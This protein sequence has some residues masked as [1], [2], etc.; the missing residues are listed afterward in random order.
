MNCFISVKT[1]AAVTSNN[2]GES[3]ESHTPMQKISVGEEGAEHFLITSESF[4]SAYRKNAQKI[5]EF[6]PRF[7]GIPHNRK[8]DNDKQILTVEF[9]QGTPDGTSWDDEAMGFLILDK[10]HIKKGGKFRGDTTV[11]NQPP[12]TILPWK[13]DVILNQS[14]DSNV[15]HEVCVRSR[16]ALHSAYQY[17]LAWNLNDWSKKSWAQ[18]GLITIGQMA[19]VAGNQRAYLYDM[20]PASLIIRLRPQLVPGFDMLA[21]NTNGSHKVIEKIL[22]GDIDGKGFFIA[23]EIICDMDATMVEQLREKG[24]VVGRNCEKMLDLVSENKDFWED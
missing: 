23:G 10:K 17:A 9:T 14:P 20:S 5:C 24:V 1:H 19:G 21:W 8:R 16:E 6:D 2:G 12:M 3:E 13:N 4:R 11:R 15:G 22:M 7:K 18:L